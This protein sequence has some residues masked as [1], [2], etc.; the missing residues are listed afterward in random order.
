MVWS[1]RQFPE[2]WS[3]VRAPAD[4]PWDHSERAHSGIHHVP[5]PLAE[6]TGSGAE[7]IASTTLA[8][9]S[10]SSARPPAILSN[11]EQSMRGKQAFTLVEPMVVIAVMT[12]FVA[13]RL[14]AFTTNRGR[15][16]RS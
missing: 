14:P 6:Y 3:E 7:R 1:V 9:G 5:R 13:I 12:P 11:P 2:A 8:G 16:F 15:A 10:P 4:A